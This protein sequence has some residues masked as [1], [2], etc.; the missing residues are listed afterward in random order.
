MA[1][2]AKEA[3][4]RQEAERQTDIRRRKQLANEKSCKE[5]ALQSKLTGRGEENAVLLARCLGI[6][7]KAADLGKQDHVEGQLRRMRKLQVVLLHM[8]HDNRGKIAHVSE[9]E[10]MSREDHQIIGQ[11]GDA[12]S[13]EV[14]VGTRPSPADA[15]AAG[16][17]V[18]VG[19]ANG[20]TDDPFKVGREAAAARA[21]ARAARVTEVVRASA[22][23]ME[24]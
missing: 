8:L 23:A 1:Q 16:T 18:T 6:L 3:E 17:M 11:A 13:S 2:E 20:G 21:Q 7:R 5:A 24:G 22:L 9:K 10:S 4:T 19:P 12:D 14:A 15:V